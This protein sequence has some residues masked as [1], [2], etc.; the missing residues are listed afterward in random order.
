MTDLKWMQVDSRLKS[1]NRSQM[2]VNRLVVFRGND[3]QVQLHAQQDNLLRAN[4]KWRHCKWNKNKNL[5]SNGTSL[6]ELLYVSKLPNRRMGQTMNRLF[7]N[8]NTQMVYKHAKRYSKVLSEVCK[9]IAQW[10]RILKQ[11]Y[12]QKLETSESIKR[13]RSAWLFINW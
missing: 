10:D 13:C 2:R 5:P 4:E 3:R 12:W 6:K 7:T 1:S 11:L 9:L 8:E